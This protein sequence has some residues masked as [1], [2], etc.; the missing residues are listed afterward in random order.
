MYLRMLAMG[1]GPER[2]SFA[3]VG[4]STLLGGCTLYHQNTHPS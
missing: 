3:T 4:G 1:E 2:M